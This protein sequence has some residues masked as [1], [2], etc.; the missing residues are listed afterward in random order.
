M[1]VSNANL[2]DQS[3]VRPEDEEAKLESP[4]KTKGYMLA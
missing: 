4:G 2:I 1:D 3:H